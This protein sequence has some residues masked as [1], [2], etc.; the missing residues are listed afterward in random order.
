MSPTIAA[1]ANETQITG[2]PLH[3]ETEPSN[4][5]F[6]GYPKIQFAGPPYREYESNPCNDPSDAG[7]QSL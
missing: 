1:H 6:F 3:L 4:F 2:S 5:V 7:V